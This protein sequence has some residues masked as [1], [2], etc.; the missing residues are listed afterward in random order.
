ITGW[1]E[2]TASQTT[3]PS[4]ALSTTIRQASADQLFIRSSPSS[5]R[6]Q[7][8]RRSC[9][10]TP[11]PLLSCRPFR[12]I[13]EVLGAPSAAPVKPDETQARGRLGLHPQAVQQ[14]HHR[15]AL[16]AYREH[17]AACRQCP[18]GPGN[19]VSESR[20]GPT[21]RQIVGEHYPLETHLSA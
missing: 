16:I 19:H 2:A 17:V 9:S 4:G 20:R 3:T 7:F 18:R 14:F 10:A 1:S 21:H 12:A 8:Q 11:Q 6:I 15:R 13:L 5:S